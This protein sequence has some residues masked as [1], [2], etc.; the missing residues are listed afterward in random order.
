[1]TQEEAEHTRSAFLFSGRQQWKDAILHAKSSNSYVLQTLVDWQ[2]LL[3]ADSGA[4]FFAINQFLTEHP[5]WPERRKLQIRAEIELAKTD[6]KSEDAIDWLTANPPI[7]GIGKLTLANA[8]QQGGKTEAGKIES[9]I[10]DAWIGGDF[11]DEQEKSLL[12]KYSGIIRQEDDISRANRLAWEGKYSAIERMSSRLSKKR[13]DLYAVRFAIQND[14][15][16]AN[17]L[18]AKLSPDLR[19]DVGLFYDRLL[20]A[21]KKDK[22]AEVWKLLL[23]AP[24]KIPYP[25]KWWKIREAKIHEAISDGN[26]AL[27]FRLLAN[28]G[29]EEKQE[30]MQGFADASWL[31]GRLL[32]TYKKQPNEA[33]QIFQK[34][35]KAVKYPVSKARASY[36][37]GRA[38]RQ[39]GDLEEAKKWFN[40]ASSYPTTFY[41]Q[42]ASA[43]YHG[44]APLRIPAP[45]VIS[46]EVRA[47]FSAR[48]LVKAVKLCISFNEFALAGKLINHLVTDADDESEALLASELGVDAGKIYLSVR[49]SKKALQNNVV[50]IFAGYPRIKTS[51]NLAIP[52]SLALAITRQESE[53]DNLAKSP[54]GALGMMQLLPSTAA[55]VARKNDMEYNP[56]KLYEADYNM[57]LG[58]LYIKRMMDNYNG[59]LIMAVAAY[60]AGMGNV[61]KWVKKF[62][63][64]AKN[65]DGAVDW[66]ENIPFAETRNYV[67]RVLENLQVYRY[68]EAQKS[69]DVSDAKLLLGNDLIR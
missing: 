33:F 4:D 63:K 9:I 44:T 46:D 69:N 1:M 38:L 23:S 47:E 24:H 48:S 56:Q 8:L 18:I 10:R 30:F 51:D 3:D 67:Q 35:F 12:A 40:I 29:Q 5:D 20:Y 43:V 2:Y 28:H 59:S 66:I 60:N 68:I 6:M 53:F 14:K 7:T 37:A 31:T 62:G 11:S 39:A 21:Y 55:E 17:K 22:D 26:M 42:L 25:E 15:K 27:A 54:A 13:M 50:S 61:Y 19:N 64:P 32:L 57:H 34:M 16:N 58:S 65:I 41:G 45:P 49:G 52:R 36:W